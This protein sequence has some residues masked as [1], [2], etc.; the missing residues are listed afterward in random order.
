MI[1]AALVLTENEEQGEGEC[2]SEGCGDAETVEG[3]ATRWSFP[4][5]ELRNEALALLDRRWRTALT[6]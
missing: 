6:S 3:D 4:S 1:P 2:R 5:T